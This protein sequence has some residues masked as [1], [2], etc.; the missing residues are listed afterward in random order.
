MLNKIK[1]E[2]S[3]NEYNIENIPCKYNKLSY[4]GTRESLVAMHL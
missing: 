1:E 2:E 3:Y 4:C